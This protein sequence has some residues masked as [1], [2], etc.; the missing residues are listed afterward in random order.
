MR[1]GIHVFADEREA[2]EAL[3]AAGFAAVGRERTQHYRHPDRDTDRW[4]RRADVRRAA[5]RG[6]HTAEVH[7]WRAFT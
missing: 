5:K 4:V 2:V 6:R 7:V 1:F 3:L